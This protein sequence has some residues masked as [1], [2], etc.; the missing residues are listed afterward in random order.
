MIIIP[1]LCPSDIPKLMSTLASVN[2]NRLGI[3]VRLLS[4]F[5][6]LAWMLDAM[7]G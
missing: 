3:V 7:A 2:H 1:S 4:S 5:S 6:P